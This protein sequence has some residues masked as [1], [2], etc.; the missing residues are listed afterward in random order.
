M[1]R[2]TLRLRACPRC[3]AA[4]SGKLADAE[5]RTT[6]AASGPS[7]LKPATRPGHARCPR[8]SRP[9]RRAVCQV[10]DLNRSATAPSSTSGSCPAGGV[11]VAVP[12]GGTGFPGCQGADGR[13]RQLGG[14]RP[15]SARQGRRRP[16]GTICVPRSLTC[17]PALVRWNVSSGAS[18]WS[19]TQPGPGFFQKGYGSKTR[20]CSRA[21]VVPL[22]V[23]Q[24]RPEEGARSG[25]F[26]RRLV[27][28]VEIDPVRRARIGAS[29]L[30]TPD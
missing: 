25:A 18:G 29:A 4:L 8:R 10:I 13:A 5:T 7:S 28:S 3:M 9:G 12:A 20:L 24:Q 1:C 11:A 27:Q 23:P 2:T 16:H 30:A 6:Q 15:G 17:L 21:S 26:P 19:V 14:S 22:L